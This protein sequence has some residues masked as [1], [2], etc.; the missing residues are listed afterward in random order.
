MQL[1]LCIR[2]HHGGVELRGAC[3]FRAVGSL[4]AT[5]GSR[6]SDGSVSR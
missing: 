5:M 6:Q 4:E 1:E 3:G 2:C